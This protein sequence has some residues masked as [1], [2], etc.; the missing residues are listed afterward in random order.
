MREI[1]I[2]LV[3]HNSSG[4]IAD[5]LDSIIAQ[6]FKDCELIVVDNASQDNTKQIL[7]NNNLDITLIENLKNY[8]YS[9][10]LNQGIARAIGKFILCLNDDIKLSNNFLKNIH[11]AI[12]NQKGVAAVQP[13][14]F[15]ADGKVIDTTGIFL[16]FLRR[17][18]DVGAGRFDG[19]EFSRPKSVFGACDAAALYRKEALETIRQGEEYFDEDFFGIVEDVDISWRLQKKGWKILYCPDATCFHS[20]GISRRKDKLSQ[21]FSMRNRY[22]LL[23]KNESLFGFLRLPVIFLVYDL[24]R[25]LYMLFFNPRYFFKASSD[26]IKLS[27]KMLKKRIFNNLAFAHEK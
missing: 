13:K 6:E 26:I 21:F 8:G 12:E 5:C 19:A 22:L 2:I 15:K 18:Y 17:F 27:P 24:W 4:Q 16:S 9:K 14:V 11:K 3:T 7:R 20:G 23:L 1:S 25:N 10:A